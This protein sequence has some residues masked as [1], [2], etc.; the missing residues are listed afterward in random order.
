MNTMERN[1]LLF[2][3]G[4]TTEQPDGYDGLCQVL[5]KRGL[6]RARI[7]RFLD[8]STDES[9]EATD[10]GILRAKNLLGTSA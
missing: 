10:E 2:L 3:A 8:G 4:L 1:A 5:A 7:T 9:Y 6:A